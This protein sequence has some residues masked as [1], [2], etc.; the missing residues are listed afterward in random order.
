MIKECKS[1]IALLWLHTMDVTVPSN[2]GAWCSLSPVPCVLIEGGFQ[3]PTEEEAFAV[4]KGNFTGLDTA[5]YLKVS[6]AVSHESLPC[7][8]PTQLGCNMPQLNA[9]QCSPVK[10]LAFGYLCLRKLFLS[11]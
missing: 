6:S 2:C 7:E 4:N 9:S 3:V 10:N 8:A 5:T 1:I 11:T